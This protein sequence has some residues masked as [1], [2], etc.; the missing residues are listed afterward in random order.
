MNDPAIVGWMNTD[1]WIRVVPVA[2]I[3]V[4]L[5][6]TLAYVLY[7][8]TRIHHDNAQYLQIGELLREGRIPYVEV[9]DTNPPLVWYLNTVP[10]VIARRIN[11]HVIPTFLVGVWL[12]S[13]ASVVG[14]RRTLRAAFSNSERIYAEAVAVAL[15][16]S[17]AAVLYWNLYGQREHLFALALFPYLAV[18]FRQ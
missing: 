2:L 16:A 9:V 14:T 7:R 10:V 18:R 17:S 6:G 15:A 12:L 5:M 11:A 3:A 13:V 8:P 4:I 1:R